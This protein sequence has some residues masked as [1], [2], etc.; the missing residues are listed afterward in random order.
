MVA[1]RPS[2]P[3]ER[4][5]VLGLIPVPSDLSDDGLL[6]SFSSFFSFFVSGFEPL[7]ALV[8]T[9]GAVTELSAF[10][11][12]DVAEV[13]WVDSTFVSGCADGTPGT[14]A[15]DCIGIVAGAVTLCVV[16]AGAVIV[17]TVLIGLSGDVGF[18]GFVKDFTQL[19]EV[20]VHPPHN[21]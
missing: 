17:D 20:V 9:D 1:A 11:A 4:P 18:V 16:I 19:S 3:I 8:P 14:S 10:G 15:G 2:P 7:C 5:F 6:V 13:V 21:G 12:S